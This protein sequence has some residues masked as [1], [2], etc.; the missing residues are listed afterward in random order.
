MI[1][2]KGCRESVV[3]SVKQI[4]Q[5]Q[6]DMGNEVL[7]I[8]IDNYDDRSISSE[9]E[10]TEAESSPSEAEEVSSERE[11]ISSHHAVGNC[12]SECTVGFHSSG[13]STVMHSIKPI[14]SIIICL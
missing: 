4:Q 9:E 11:S 10:S 3:D 12:E 7:R 6:K 14:L 1:Q 2:V 13:A 8:E 5:E